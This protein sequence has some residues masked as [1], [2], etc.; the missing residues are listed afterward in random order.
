MQSVDLSTRVLACAQAAHEAN[1]AYCAALGD[2]S[3][4]TW[5]AAPDW[6]RESAIK[7]VEGVLRGNDPKQSHESWL[8]EKVRTGWKF[9]AVKDP[10]K[11]EHP[12]M[13]PYEDLPPEQRAKDHVFVNVVKSLATALGLR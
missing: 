3:Q 13:V 1:R 8:E 5:E 2:N 10:D 6:Q 9:G 11:K 4:V 7:G 12:C